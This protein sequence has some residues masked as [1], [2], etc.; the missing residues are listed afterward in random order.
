MR[1]ARTAPAGGGACGRP[2]HGRR[3]RH[4]VDRRRRGADAAATPGSSAPPPAASAALPPAAAAAAAAPSREEGAARAARERCSRGI[5]PAP[6]G[7]SV[8]RRSTPPASLALPAAPSQRTLVSGRPHRTGAD[9]QVDRRRPRDARRAAAQQVVPRVAAARLGER[10]GVADA[11]ARAMRC[12]SSTNPAAVPGGSAAAHVP[13]ESPAARR[14]G[15]AGPPYAVPA[16]A[17][18]AQAQRR[19]LMGGGRLRPPCTHG[20]SLV[21]IGVAA[22]VEVATSWARRA[23]AGSAARAPPP[24]GDAGYP[25]QSLAEWMVALRLVKRRCGPRV[26]R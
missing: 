8:S 16:R 10:R 18:R 9:R 26:P 22:S 7:G 11:G 14:C 23:A 4:R 20:L 12:P 3:P 6:A 13:D 24:A 15:S 25:T 5:P 21:D 2:L 17:A 19:A 1:S